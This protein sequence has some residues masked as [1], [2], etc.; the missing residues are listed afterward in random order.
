MEYL[1]AK[2]INGFLTHAVANQPQF[3]HRT[4]PW[5]LVTY[6]RALC[7]VGRGGMRISL[8]K[9]TAEPLPYRGIDGC[10]RCHIK[11]NKLRQAEG[12]G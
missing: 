12:K 4:A 9:E 7:G 6:V 8:N 1:D 5:I 3:F 2:P 10:D 11:L